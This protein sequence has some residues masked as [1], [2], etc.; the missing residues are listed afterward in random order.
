MNK[1]RINL[2]ESIAKAQSL[3]N[4]VEQEPEKTNQNIDIIRHILSE[5]KPN[6]FFNE[7]KTENVDISWLNKEQKNNPEQ[8]NVVYKSDDKD[9]LIETEAIMGLTDEGRP[10]WEEVVNI[11]KKNKQRARIDYL[12]DEKGWPPVHQKINH[13]T[14]K[15]WVTLPENRE[16]T[17]S[18]EA[19]LESPATRINPL[20][21]TG[22]MG[23]GKS[24]L[25][26]AS[27]TSMQRRDPTRYV[28]RIDGQALINLIEIPKNW[29]DSLPDTSL[30]IFD[31]LDIL[32]SR[33][34]LI[35]IVGSI[36]DLAL[37]LGV[38]VIISAREWDIEAL[39]RGRLGRMIS[40]SIPIEI[41]KPSRT[42]TILLLRR[43]AML[44]RVLI[45]DSQLEAIVHWSKGK[46]EAAIS[47]FDRLRQLIEGGYLLNTDLA[48][49]EALDGKLEAEVAQSDE[50]ILLEKSAEEIFEQSLERTTF[51]PINKDKIEIKNED[52]E[53][54]ELKQNELEEIEEIII[55]EA[56][57][58]L[59]N[60]KQFTE[61]ETNRFVS[62]LK[63][64]RRDR[65][66]FSPTMSSEAEMNRAI[67]NH[68]EVI[69]STIEVGVSLDA[70]LDGISLG[71]G[72]VEE[73]NE[74]DKLANRLDLLS[75]EVSRLDTA[76][77][78]EWT[79]DGSWVIEEK[80]VEVS[81]LF[82]DEDFD[83]PKA[84]LKIRHQLIPEEE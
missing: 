37:N 32:H 62:E 41:M 76:Q 66:K 9:S 69:K 15:Q 49:I 33:D 52:Y 51:T 20:I 35:E 2:S 55:Q 28:R 70:A 30:L 73:E 74:L 25:L 64:R 54:S 22:S 6:D 60:E 53:I 58:N 79:P 68:N 21:I 82:D 63:K 26:S 71:V 16:A 77:L 34:D 42:S 17:H 11:G 5:K 84:T 14:F 72:Q 12:N 3:L 65:T 57:E 83:Q 13:F 38:Q 31:D 19:V 43:R 18:T 7:E 75:K 8:Q 36:I 45:G 50:I 29:A 4:I 27:A 81:D 80:E 39:Q 10:I 59:E 40:S 23:V 24:H 56:L 46:L 48:I 61:N 78:D 47:G 1:K 44:Q 67:A